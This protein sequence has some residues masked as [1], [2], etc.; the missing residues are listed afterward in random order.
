MHKILFLLISLSVLL[1]ACGNNTE[2]TDIKDFTVSG[3]ISNVPQNTYISL[4]HRTSKN[5]ETLDSVMIIDST[6]ELSA[7]ISDKTEFFL[8]KLSN[9]DYY[10]YLLADSGDN[11][12]IN[13]DFLKS[14]QYKIQNSEESELIQILENQLFLTNIKIDSL[15]NSKADISKIE[16]LKNEQKEFS[17]HFVTLNGESMAS[18]IALSERFITGEPVLPI[19]EY[20]EIHTEVDKKLRTKYLQSEYYLQFA[21]FIKN[22]E[23]NLNRQNANNAKNETPTTLVNF[24][25]QTINGENFELNSLSGKWILLNFW[26]SWSYSCV[27]NN[28]LLQIIAQKRPDINIVQI[29]IDK[30]ENILKDTLS[31]YN[32]NHILINDT[33]GWNSEFVNLYNIESLPTNI[34]INPKGEIVL[35]SG[36]MEELENKVL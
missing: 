6:F 1:S 29:S 33:K 26:A 23:I 20:Y 17:L 22:Y 10:I 5:T 13:A 9:N 7:N 30:K 16:A 31:H 27:A 18:I 25:A 28:Q 19:E 4:I 32:F 12:S 11:I 14:Q 3:V 36:N 2:T 24:S 21:E 8:L 35:F 34:L 15:I